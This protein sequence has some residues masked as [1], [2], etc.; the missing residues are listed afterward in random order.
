MTLDDIMLL[1]DDYADK[2]S[3]WWGVSTLDAVTEVGI[4]RRTLFKAIQELSVET[5]ST[6]HERDSTYDVEMHDDEVDTHG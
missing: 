1:A 4:A 2:H 5:R 3:R 6:H